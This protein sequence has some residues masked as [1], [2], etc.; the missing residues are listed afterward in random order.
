MSTYTGYA[1]GESIAVNTAHVDVTIGKAYTVLNVNG[2][3]VEIR[4]D[5]GD[6]HNIP[7]EYV[8]Y[9][10]KVS[11]NATCGSLNPFVSG[12]DVTCDTNHIKYLTRGKAY[13][14]VSVSGTYVRVLN[15]NSTV[16]GYHYDH[17]SL[18]NGSQLASP[19]Q[20]AMGA[21]NRATARAIPAHITPPADYPEY[22]VEEDYD[23]RKA[24]RSVTSAGRFNKGDV[25]VYCD[26]TITQTNLTVTRCT[27]TCV[28]FE[29][30][31]SMPFDP[32]EFTLEYYDE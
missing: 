6:L 7:M 19:H 4:D 13:M 27:A 9:A 1:K 22:E 16:D 5:A 3:H 24:N 28:W 2:D 10:L 31:Y 23:T 29:E 14:V 21:G 18:Y 25:L 30:T 17:F 8:S 11:T 15:D 20:G 12:N 32:N 26:G